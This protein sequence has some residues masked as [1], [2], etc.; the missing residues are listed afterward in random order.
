M[1]EDKVGMCPVCLK[2]TCE[3]GNKASADSQADGFK[4]AQAGTMV[5][6]IKGEVQD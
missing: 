5:G 2:A 4:A 1:D 3:C 6:S